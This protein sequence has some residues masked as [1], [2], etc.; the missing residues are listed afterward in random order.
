MLSKATVLVVD[1]TQSVTLFVSKIL[2]EQLN[3]RKVKSFR[4]ANNALEYIEEGGKVDWIISDWEMP[5]MTGDEFLLKVRNNPKTQDIPFIMLTS[6]NDRDSLIT[7]AQ[8]GVSDFI[9]KPFSA[10]V[11]MQKVRKVFLSC[12]RRLMERFKATTKTPVKIEIEGG[13]PNFASLVDLSIG[14]CLVRLP[15]GANISCGHIYGHAKLNIQLED[16]EINVDGE[17]IRVERDRDEPQSRKYIMVAFQ[18]G[19][20]D[21]RN[22]VKLERV[23]NS[24]KDDLPKMVD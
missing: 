9:I 1:D 11:L 2:R 21:N 18:F 12:E 24:I 14:G 17:L 20:V 22:K 16:D 3:C 10:A 7:A 13:V 5:G 23:L 19:E 4:T 15:Y 8:A 6:R